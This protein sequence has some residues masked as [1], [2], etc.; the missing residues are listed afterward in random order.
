MLVPFQ[1]IKFSYELELNQTQE[2]ALAYKKIKEFYGEQI[3]F[4]LLEN[5]WRIEV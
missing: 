1:H 3:Y 2:L 5:Q 4:L